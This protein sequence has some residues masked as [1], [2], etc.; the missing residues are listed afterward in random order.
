MRHLKAHF[1][2][3]QGELVLCVC[4]FCFNAILL[5]KNP[6]SEILSDIRLELCSPPIC[7]FPGLGEN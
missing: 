6:C 4:V 5:S 7:R 2:Q 3:S 1:S